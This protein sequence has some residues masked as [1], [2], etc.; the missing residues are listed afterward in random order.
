MRSCW[1]LL[2]SEIES[3]L[4][5]RLLVNLNQDGSVAGS[6]QILEQDNSP[7]GIAIARAAVTAVRKCGPY[8][9]AAEKYDN[10][11]QVDVTFR[12]SEL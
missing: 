10:W 6:P 7:I 5:V 8:R 12:S 3:R 9:L 2:P 1:N 11:R 4:S